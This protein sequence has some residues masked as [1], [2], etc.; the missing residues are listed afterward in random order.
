MIC[1]GIYTVF[2]QRQLAIAAGSYYLSPVPG[3]FVIRV[4]QGEWTGVISGGDR[5]CERGGGLNKRHTWVWFL[6][7]ALAL[8]LPGCGG[9]VKSATQPMIDNLATAIQKQD[10]P[11]L[12]RDGAPAYL[13]LIDGMVEG[14]PDD[15]DTLKTAATLYSSYVSAFVAGQDKPRAKVLAARA[16]DYAFRAAAIEKPLFGELHDRPYK[17]FEPVAAAFEAGDEELLFLVA[18]TWAGVV[19]SDSGNTDLLADIAKIDLLARRLL[20]LDETYYY[21]AAHLALG[22]LNTIVP[23]TLGGKPKVAREH[24]DK[25]LAIGEG[26]FLPAYVMYAENYAKKMFDKELFVSLLE[27]TLNT[28]ADIEPKLTLVNTLAKRQAEALLA[29]ADEYFD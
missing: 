25:A 29:E 17:E 1:G 9:L 24:F 22:V 7:L 10:D 18:G 12:V 27:K 26:K 13:L 23:P 5:S 8:V 28:P 15:P 3:F 2:A 11:E 19:Q 20:E 4:G 21:G 6:A 14:S 16:R